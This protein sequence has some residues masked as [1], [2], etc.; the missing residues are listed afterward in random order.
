[1]EWIFLYLF[2]DTFSQI[3]IF[4]IFDTWQ[5]IWLKFDLWK[6]QKKDIFI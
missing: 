6:P 4:K 5:D 1:M 2:N 3:M